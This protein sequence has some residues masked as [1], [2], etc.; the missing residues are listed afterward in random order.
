MKKDA[1]KPTFRLRF[2]R[3]EISSLAEQ[4]NDENPD[5]PLEDDLEQM[6]GPRMRRDH[7]LAKKDFLELCKWKTKRTQRACASN[8]D[9]FLEAV[10]RIALT[11]SCEE[12]RI[13]VATL[14]RGVDWPTSSVI[15]HFGYDNQYPILDFRALK[16]LG[17]KQPTQYSFPFWQEYTNYCRRLA[18]ECGVTLR[19]L[20]R[21]LWQ[22]SKNKAKKH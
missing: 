1:T 10:T 17:V 13:S 22:Y 18:A 21:A 5:R 16:S 2:S 6:I 11:T 9:Y 3:N 8:S 7:C 19:V 4:Y 20:D 15:L 12:L 14:L